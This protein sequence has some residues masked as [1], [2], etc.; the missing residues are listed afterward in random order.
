[1][2]PQPFTAS[3]CSFLR[4]SNEIGIFILKNMTHLNSKQGK[5]PQR[6]HIMMSSDHGR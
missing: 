6:I 5:E 3:K 1:M 4:I 2:P